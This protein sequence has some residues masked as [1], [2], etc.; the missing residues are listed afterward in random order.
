MVYIDARGHIGISATGI[1]PEMAVAIA[2]ELRQLANTIELHQH[3]ERRRRFARH[4]QGYASLAALAGLAFI[5]ATYLNPLDWLDAALS[6]AAQVTA[7]ILSI[8]STRKAPNRATT[9]GISTHPR[10][11]K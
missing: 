6:L 10:M 5:A 11:P 1:E 3:Q 9:K 2:D 7:A 4:E 8:Q